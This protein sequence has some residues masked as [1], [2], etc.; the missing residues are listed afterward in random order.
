MSL[1]P[2][3]TIVVDPPW[4][5][6]SPGAF[7]GA[8]NKRGSRPTYKRMTLQQIKDFVIPVP[9]A[10]QAHCW[11]WTTHEHLMEADDVLEA[12]GFRPAKTGR[13]WQKTRPANGYWV[14]QDVEFLRLGVRGPAYRANAKAILGYHPRS[15]FKAPAPRVHSAKPDLFYVQTKA[16]SPGPWASIFERTPR[17][18]WY[19]WGDEYMPEPIV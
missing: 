1:P 6:R 3:G 19:G 10:E 7:H 8:N 12:W 4:K 11:L 13:V 2:F 9:V 18:G 15:L 17:S 16:I 5:H 14:G